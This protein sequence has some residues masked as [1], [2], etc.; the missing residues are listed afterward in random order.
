M[1]ITFFG[2]VQSVYKLLFIINQSLAETETS[3]NSVTEN[4]HTE[5]RWTSIAAAVTALQTKIADICRILK[6]ISIDNGAN[7]KS[8]SGADRLLNCIDFPFLCLLQMW[9]KVLQQIDRVNR[10]LQAKGISVLTAAQMLNG[11]VE[12]IQDLRNT[13]TAELFLLAKSVAEYLNMEAS[14]PSI[15]VNGGEK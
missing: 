9:N 8:R 7:T 15:E 6:E 12:S 11:L 2:T 5:T 3:T 1:M 14:F 10:S 4:T 13:G